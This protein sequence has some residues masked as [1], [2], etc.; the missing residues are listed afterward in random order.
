MAR[1]CNR[2]HLGKV[3]SDEKKK[4][5]RSGAAKPPVIDVKAQKVEGEK[6]EKSGKPAA[7]ENATGAQGASSPPPEKGKA[8]GKAPGDAGADGG[9][10]DESPAP[11]AKAGASGKQGKEQGKERPR[12]RRGWFWKGL[13]GLLLLGGAAGGGAWLYQQY[14]PEKKLAAMQARLAALEKKA[15]GAD[16][17]ALAQRV[18]A[19][20]AAQR[21]L[22]A[23]MKK[24]AGLTA[25]PQK[26]ATL[27]ER[28]GAIGG[29]KKQVQENAQALREMHEAFAKAQ[30]QLATLKE[31][32]M[33]MAQA[34]AA[35]PAGEAGTAGASGAPAAAVAPTAALLALK[36]SLKETQQ[37]MADLAR[38]LSDL[39]K[40]ADP[41]RMEML[42]GRLKKQEEA[43]LRL[44]AELQDSIDKAMEQAL[45]A[46]QAAKTARK[47]VAD[48]RAHPPAPKIVP[49]PAA[50]AYAA[51]REKVKAGAPFAAELKKLTALLPGAKP[52]DALAPFAKA[53]VPTTR[54]LAAELD[55]VIAQLEKS[56]SAAAAGGDGDVLGAL[57]QRL[58]KV[59]KVRRAGEVDWPEVTRKMRA[60]LAKGGL[61]AALA[62]LPERGGAMPKPLA[63]WVGKARARQQ[64]DA[65][66]DALADLVLRQTQGK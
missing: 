59:V 58:S 22:S 6:A 12:R 44:R 29:L 57:T 62:A 10:K 30:E 25:L 26:V 42:E 20:E 4:P 49:P 13:F 8:S 46:E 14:G 56:S 18:D 48:L 66:L 32:I 2:G 40:A 5:G 28:V 21:K 55:T 9:K 47:A 45:K 51:L 39:R 7:G 54:A 61:G 33:Q 11:D 31:G 24:L 16:V 65:A 27:E 43:L 52:L 15:A 63:A 34:P 17:K 60:E 53:G 1:R 36:L 37:K 50:M 35:A 3:M 19:L 64:V 41:A 38:Q 23:E